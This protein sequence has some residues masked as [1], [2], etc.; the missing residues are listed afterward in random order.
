MADKTPP[1]F[2]YALKHTL[3]FEGGYANDPADS[4]GETFRGVSRRNWPGWFGWK[5]IDQVKADGLRSASAINQRF[6]DDPQMAELVADFYLCNFWRPFSGLSEMERLQVKLFDTAVN[7]GVGRAVKLLQQALN[8]LKSTPARLQ[9]D[10]ALG[11]ITMAVARGLLE[12]DIL[13]AFTSSQA[14]FYQGIVS[15]KPSQQKFL[16]SWLR[17]AAWVPV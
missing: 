2:E 6:A 11:P 8:T 1:A 7:T 10:G 12:Q 14:L 17:R 16:K 3:Q 5:L 15:R 9:V 4:G 13:C